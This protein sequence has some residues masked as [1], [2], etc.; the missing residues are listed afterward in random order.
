MDL[1]KF[2]EILANLLAAVAIICI[3][4][5]AHAF[6]AYKCGD[7]TA[8]YA[9]RMTLNPVKHFDLLGMLMFGLAGFGW[10]KPVPINPN[11]FKRYKLGTFLTSAAGILANLLFA[12][13]MYPLFQLI[14]LYVFPY[15]S[16]KNLGWFL[17]CLFS[18]LYAMSLNFAA[19]NLLPL[20]PLD[21][22]RIVEAF[23]KKRGK[24]F[25]FLRNYGYYILLALILI[26]LAAKYIDVF[27]YIDLLGFVM[28]WLTTALDYPI[29]LFWGLIF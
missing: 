20:Y 13:L 8:K 15:I 28:F 27:A 18:S 3:H 26:N 12:F 24:V 17:I 19:F 23:N 14:V 10:S 16:G 4:E 11:N 9:G 21:G 29:S 7:S 5:F 2:I 1:T 6:T 22:F 25:R